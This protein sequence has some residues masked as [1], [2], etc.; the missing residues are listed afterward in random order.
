MPTVGTAAPLV[1]DDARGSLR[2]GTPGAQPVCVGRR[3]AMSGLPERS[4]HER[5]RVSARS[6]SRGRL[7]RDERPSRR[8]ARPHAAPRPSRPARLA[9]L[10][11]VVA[12]PSALLPD[13]LGL[14]HRS[15]FAQLVSFRPAHARRPAGARR[16]RDR[17]SPSCAGG[18]GRSPVGLLAVAPVGGAMVLPRALPARDVPE[19]DAPAARTL[20]VLSFNTYE[21]HADVDAVAAL[22]R[23][24]R[25]DLVALPEAAGR[26]RDR[27]APLVPDY[28][29]APSNERGR[30]V[31]GVTAAAC[32]PTSA[33]SRS[34]STAA[35]RFPSVEVTGGGARRPALRRLPLRSRPSPATSRSG[36]ATWPRSTAGARTGSPAR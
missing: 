14:D 30:D 17:W 31:Q 33:T 5:G 12:A 6:R 4:C 32:G 2:R 23:S 24:S 13:L 7:E 21:G 8:A 19:P 26:F 11:V 16:R 10:L 20:T 28:R 35:T 27:L 18:A 22:I 1:H 29:F 34:R 3:R 36:A 25:P 9:L 15:P